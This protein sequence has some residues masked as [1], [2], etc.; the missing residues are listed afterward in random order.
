MLVD[1]LTSGSEAVEITIDGVPVGI[2]APGVIERHYMQLPLGTNTINFTVGVLSVNRDFEV[3]ATTSYF[4]FV[5]DE[6]NRFIRS[7][8]LTVVFD[9]L[10]TPSEV[11]TIL[12]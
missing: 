11:E 5:L 9:G 3:L 6:V 12:R 7:D 2:Q 8:Y 1:Y 4:H 10:I